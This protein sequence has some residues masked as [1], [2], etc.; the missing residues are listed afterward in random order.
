LFLISKLEKKTFVFTRPGKAIEQNRQMESLE[1]EIENWRKGY[2]QF[3][4]NWERLSTNA[5]LIIPDLQEKIQA[6]K[7]LK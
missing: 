1:A 4:E 3:L 2:I 5:N 7:Q 6:T